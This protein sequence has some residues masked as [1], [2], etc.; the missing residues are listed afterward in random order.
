M[1][2]GFVKG[3]V[4]SAGMKLI[5][6]DLCE[7]DNPAG[8]FDDPALAG[9][10]GRPVADRSGGESR[11]NTSEVFGRL[12]DGRDIVSC[13]CEP[14]LSRPGILCWQR[15]L[16]QRGAAFVCPK[17]KPGLRSA[18]QGRHGHRSRPALAR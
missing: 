5:D 16:S 8:T 18:D 9:S 2:P 4:A 7:S 14:F 1:N 10:T 11:V 12:A 15:V 3:K 6:S 17:P 13:P